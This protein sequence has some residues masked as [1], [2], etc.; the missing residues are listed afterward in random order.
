[1]IEAVGTNT[2]GSTLTFALSKVVAQADS[3]V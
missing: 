2:Q 3:R 1:M